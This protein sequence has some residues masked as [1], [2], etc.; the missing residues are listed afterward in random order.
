AKSP[1]EFL[2]PVAGR[3]PVYLA[4][5]L[6]AANGG[7]E[8]TE[9]SLYELLLETPS[10]QHIAVVGGVG[11]TIALLHSFWEMVRDYSESKHRG[12]FPCWLQ[13]EDELF[14]AEWLPHCPPLVIF[15]DLD[16]FAPT[17]RERTVE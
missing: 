12:Y 17:T 3:H 2:L 1:R 5:R 15:A 13:T 7:G 9:A 6:Q 11:K 8:V 4:Q 10:D 14:N 16:Q